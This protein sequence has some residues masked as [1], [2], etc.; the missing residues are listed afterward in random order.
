M[1]KIE[2]ALTEISIE[3]ESEKD[4]KR[5]E[6]L[7]LIEEEIYASGTSIKYWM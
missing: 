3:N 4:L 5:Y 7:Q 6:G 1:E 2:K